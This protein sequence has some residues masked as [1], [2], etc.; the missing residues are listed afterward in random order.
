MTFEIKFI[1]GY[2]EKYN[3]EPGEIAP[4]TYGMYWCMVATGMSRLFTSD[5]LEEF[6]FR[7]AIVMENTKL[8]EN[9]FGWDQF[10]LFSHND[11]DYV[12]SAQDVLNHVG[13]EASNSTNNYISR[14]DFLNNIGTRITNAQFQGTF[15]GNFQVLKPRVKRNEVGTLRFWSTA[16]EYVS[17]ITEAL[18]S[19]AEFFAR[20]ILKNATPD[21]FI[22]TDAAA[23]QLKEIEKR[24]QNIRDLPRFDFDQVP[25]DVTEDCF[26]A[27]FDMKY[28]EQLLKEPSSN[29]YRRI[30]KKY[31]YLAWLY[32]NELLWIVNGYDFNHRE[33]IS[34][35][36]QEYADGTGGC[37]IP[38]F[39]DDYNMNECIPFLKGL[40]SDN[41]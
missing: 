22:L 19:K 7:L 6:L 10:I 20:D 41:E 38:K 13:F 34:F 21:S 24:L 14:E 5:Q 36:P 8:V 3:L 28:A 18:K 25:K 32:A 30:G 9:W 1:L 26:Y 23:N 15:V 29:E 12:L 37:N 40:F 39:I 11:L 16:K 17:D 4:Q 31:I 35:D 2:H 33:G 27:M